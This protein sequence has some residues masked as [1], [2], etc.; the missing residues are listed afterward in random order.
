MM[1]ARVFIIPYACIYVLYSYICIYIYIYVHII[2]MCRAYI[3]YNLLGIFQS[4]WVLA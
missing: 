4:I 2:Y 1:Q 3:I